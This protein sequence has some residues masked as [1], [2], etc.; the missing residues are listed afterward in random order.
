TPLNDPN[1]A[2]PVDAEQNKVMAIL[3]YIIFLIPLLAARG[4]RFAMYHTNQGLLLFLFGVAVNIIGS[5]IPFLGWMIIL[6]VGNIIWFVFAIL[7]IVN[8]AGGK[9]K[10]LPLIGGFTLIK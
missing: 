6:P 10:P 4:S 3:G 7:G 8:A 9:M 2:D 1:I 5:I